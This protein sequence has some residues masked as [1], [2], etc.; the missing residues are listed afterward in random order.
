MCSKKWIFDMIQLI[1]KLR[2]MLY[3]FILKHNTE[4]NQNVC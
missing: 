4:I 3:I 1:C 2:Y